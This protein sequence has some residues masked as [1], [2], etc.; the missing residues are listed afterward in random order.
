MVYGLALR[1]FALTGVFANPLPKACC[2]SIRACF[3]RKQSYVNIHICKI[4][5]DIFLI[6]LRPVTCVIAQATCKKR[7]P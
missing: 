3:R 1:G 6:M 5:G 4:F 2:V 7:L